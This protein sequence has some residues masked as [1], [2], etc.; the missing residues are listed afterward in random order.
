VH[1]NL[2]KL[3][4]KGMSQVAI[5]GHCICISHDGINKV[6]EALPRIELKDVLCVK[7]YGPP[8][9]ANVMKLKM[10]SMHQFQVSAEKIYRWLSVLKKI[11]PF[12]KDLELIEKDV[13]VKEIHRELENILEIGTDLQPQE[14]IS[15]SN[16]VENDADLN[17]FQFVYLDGKANETTLEDNTTNFIETIEKNLHSI[18]VKESK[19]VWNDIES[20]VEI[21]YLTFPSLFV[22]GT[23]LP[24][25]PLNTNSMNHLLK[26]YDQRFATDME[27]IFYLFNVKMR[28][29][30]IMKTSLYIK[31]NPQAIQAISEFLADP[32][33]ITK[34]R[35]AK[36]NPKSKEAMKLVSLLRSHIQIA[37]ER[38]P[39]SSSERGLHLSQLVGYCR[40]FGVPS[41]FVTISPS[42]SDN[43][44]IMKL[45]TGLEN[46]ELRLLSVNQRCEISNSNPVACA[47]VFFRTV[48]NVMKQ[49]LKLD[50]VDDIRTN[51]ESIE[52]RLR[53]ILGTPI[54]FFGV[55]ETQG[56]GALHI[57]F[58]VWSRIGP[59]ALR[60]AAADPT[61][62]TVIA[63]VIDS[64]TCASIPLEFH[65]QN[66]QRIAQKRA[67]RRFLF[68]STSSVYRNLDFYDRL[69]QVAAILQTHVHSSTCHKGKIGKTRC[70][71]SRPQETSTTTHPVLLCIEN[72]GAI[73]SSTIIPP[74]KVEHG[75]NEPFPYNDERLI[76]WK[77]KRQ[78]LTEEGVSN[79]LITEFN[80][81]LSS[82]VAS[83]TCVS[84]LG[85]SCQAKSATFYMLK[86][87]TKDP[88]AA[89]ST[90]TCIYEAFSKNNIQSVAE[91]AG[92]SSRNATLLIQRILNRKISHSE[93][94]Q[95]LAAS[96][97]LGY[98][99]T[100]K[101]HNT[102]YC[103]ASSAVKLLQQIHG[104]I[105]S[106]TYLE[107]EHILD[108]QSVGEPDWEIDDE[109][110]TPRYSTN[111]DIE[112]QIGDFVE[113]NSA[114]IIESVNFIE[115]NGKYSPKI[116]VSQAINY[117]YRGPQLATMSLY[118][119]S[120]MVKIEKIKD[121]TTNPDFN[122]GRK[123]NPSFSF[124]S[125][126]PEESIK[127]QVLLSKYN[128][129]CIA[130]K[131]FPR[132]PGFR[133]AS[134]FSETK[135]NTWAKYVAVTF[136]PWGSSSNIDTNYD[137]ITELLK[138]W[139]NGSTIERIRYKIIHD[140]AKG[141]SIP[142]ETHKIYAEYRGQHAQIWSMQERIIEQSSTNVYEQQEP[143]DPLLL[144]EAIDLNILKP[145]YLAAKSYIDE[146]ERYFENIFENTEIG[147]YT[148]FSN[149]SNRDLVNMWDCIKSGKLTELDMDDV[150]R[151]ENVHNQLSSNEIQGNQLILN[152]Q[153]DNVKRYVLQQ[154]L[155]NEQFLL[156]LVG[157]PGT[158][159]STVVNSILDDIPDSTALCAAP[160]GIAATLLRNGKTI[161][162][163]LCFRIGSL[164]I[165]PLKTSK[166]L[167][168]QQIFSHVKLLV[169]DEASMI[170]FN[171]MYRINKR[172]QEIK[173]NNLDF[174]GIS[175]L[176]C[177]DFYQLPPVSSEPWQTTILS[178]EVAIKDSKSRNKCIARGLMQKFN[179][180]EL[181][182]QQRSED[183][184]HTKNLELCRDPNTSTYDIVS[185]YQTMTERE[186]DFTNATVIVVS[187]EERNSV[188]FIQAK[189][190]AKAKGTPVIA[191]YKQPK[192]N[193][194]I[195]SGT[196]SHIYENNMSL[197]HLFV[198]GAPAILLENL[199]VNLKLAN[200]TPAELY[201]LTLNPITKLEDER[202][203]S[204]AL[205]GEVVIINEPFAVNIELCSNSHK[206][207]LS[208]WPL[209]GKLN[210][211]GKL[212][213]PLVIENSFTQTTITFNGKKL[214][215]KS[216]PFDLKFAVTFHKAQGQ[217]M[218]NIILDI[219]CRPK[220]LGILQFQS[221]YVGLS[222]VKT[223]DS[224]RIVPYHDLKTIQQLQRLKADGNIQKWMSLYES[225]PETPFLKRLHIQ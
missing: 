184:T 141:L 39:Y 172:L 21:C 215:F 168:L 135:A 194:L 71:L 191:W 67:Y 59:E 145:G 65:V 111:A 72:K 83:N 166:L 8:E 171:K 56:R 45:A 46:D 116:Q 136:V 225:I 31:S 57:H 5:K 95:T 99:S 54:A 118:E 27:F 105:D 164:D 29:E 23:G 52:A 58:A 162:S 158:G 30:A 110:N 9:H 19:N 175:I 181:V 142:S 108:F 196:L 189:S 53:G 69:Y 170:D 122:C 104:N 47:E 214:S 156:L 121:K 74:E 160:T 92:T 202:K 167:E 154:L 197:L 42:D 16:I 50:P 10:R 79:G 89:A 35:K 70:R 187:N 113:N 109:D 7:Y 34:L 212:V 223:G 75:N 11:N 48:R 185:K 133:T 213:I 195:D 124:E 14:N 76:F 151:D 201:S 4:W 140:F 38:V 198:P 193:I 206:S 125:K 22:L 134:T 98:S 85:D 88:T 115:E 17:S 15:T 139:K 221:F 40:H 161:D 94:S 204:E 137:N 152:P 224:I 32:E 209:E 186:K 183:E 61:S 112:N 128:V 211:P 13:F 80:P 114:D 132:W 217:T 180:A 12:Y 144:Q 90:I 86:Y 163:L 177:G 188:N 63:K 159:K 3:S 182:I 208:V 77:Q 1:L 33:M 106:E 131:S 91:D 126:H 123:T 49:L 37:G 28:H 219:R 82:T 87:M 101:S 174:G 207:L 117:L 73:Y 6:V 203:I 102:S 60:L 93:Y 192:Q 25:K 150:E 222:R 130:G 64:M 220:L 2:V 205:A 62:T 41:W 26:F 148:R 210:I 78:P 169:I 43:P 199:N 155:K 165:Q 157:G 179:L 36:D 44:L 100:I 96:V 103:F 107:D 68:E 24:K 119:Y 51:H 153:Q 20:I 55:F 120:A 97:L 176:F 18:E 190:M 143:F 138:T 200:G 129:P 147:E 173:A 127:K 146:S 218:G 66:K 84:L 178:K 149:Q 216:F 81:T